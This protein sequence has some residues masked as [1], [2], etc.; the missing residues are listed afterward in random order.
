ML[1]LKTFGI[2]EHF[3]YSVYTWDE[4]CEGR[5]KTHRY[6]QAAECKALVPD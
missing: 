6:N 2:L 1:V 3:G 5:E 4:R